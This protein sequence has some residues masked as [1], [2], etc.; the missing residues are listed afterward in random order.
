MPEIWPYSMQ[1]RKYYDS[2]KYYRQERRV[3]MK[4]NKTCKICGETLSTRKFYHDENSPD[5]YEDFCKKCKRF[6]VILI[7]NTCYIIL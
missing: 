5:G 3:K 2:N 4:L 1:N 6:L 7:K